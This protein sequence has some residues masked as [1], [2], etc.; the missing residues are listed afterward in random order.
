MHI[1]CH[2]ASAK[3]TEPGGTI[4]SWAGAKPHSPEDFSAVA[5]KPQGG[6][7]RGLPRCDE[8]TVRPL[9]QALDHEI[10][11]PSPEQARNP[12]RLEGWSLSILVQRTT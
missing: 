2:K 4:G 11:D 10:N 8:M 7:A 9:Y 5:A 12:S 1:M 6:Q 3:K